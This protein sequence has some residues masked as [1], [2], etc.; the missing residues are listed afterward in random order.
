[1]FDPHPCGD[2]FGAI[3]PMRNLLFG[4]VSCFLRFFN[5]WGSGDQ[6][7]LWPRKFHPVAI[8]SQINIDLKLDLNPFDH[9]YIYCGQIS[10]T[11]KVVVGLL[12]QYLLLLDVACVLGFSA[13]RN[14]TSSWMMAALS[15]ATSASEKLPKRLKPGTL[16]TC[17]FY[18]M[19]MA[20]TTGKTQRL[21]S[22]LHVAHPA[23]S[24]WWISGDGWPDL[25]VALITSLTWDSCAKTYVDD[26][27]T[28][29]TE[30][31]MFQDSQIQRHKRIWHPLMLV[32]CKRF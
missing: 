6:G 16:G 13:D 19:K 8:P 5:L 7:S 20:E 10:S 17:R 14:S 2:C 22:H 3:D 12:V 25:R 30:I 18:L 26:C 27:G 21:A 4:F 15:S 29:F 1:M 11:T 23:E 28:C 24:R 32:G 9:I 31:I